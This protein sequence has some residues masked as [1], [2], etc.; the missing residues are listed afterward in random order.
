MGGLRPSVIYRKVTDGFWSER[1]AQLS[2]AIVSVVGPPKTF[3]KIALEAIADVLN[4]SETPLSAPSA[5]G[6]ITKNAL[7][8]HFS[9][10]RPS[11][12]RHSRNFRQNGD[13]ENVFAGLLDIHAAMIKFVSAHHQ[14]EMP[15]NGR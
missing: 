1:G 11:F 12:W 4:R 9:D 8:G 7:S 5:C 14:K 10:V 6:M 15:P 3:G 13:C 2:A